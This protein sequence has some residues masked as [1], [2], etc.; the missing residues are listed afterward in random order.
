MVSELGSPWY[1]VRG[2]ADIL[3]AL[4]PFPHHG[5]LDKGGGVEVP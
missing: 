4:V 3:R 1:A 2:T 5:P